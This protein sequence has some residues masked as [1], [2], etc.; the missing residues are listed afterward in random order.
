MRFMQRRARSSVRELAGV[1]VTLAVGIVLVLGSPMAG[2][3]QTFEVLH[4]FQGGT[5]DGAVPL[6]R[7][8][9][10]QGNDGYFYGTTG[11]GG[12]RGTVFQ[13]DTSGT[14]TIL[15]AFTGSPD[16]A[17]PAS[18]LIQAM[19]GALYGT[20]TRGG[21]GPCGAVGCGTVYKITTTGQYTQLWAFNGMNGESP[22]GALIQG[23]DGYF[24]GTT[25]RGGTLDYGVVFKMDAAGM[26]TTVHE[27]SLSEGAFPNASL[28]Q[29]RDGLLY[30]TTVGGGPSGRGTIFSMDPSGASFSVVHA[31]GPTEG[32]SPLSALLEASDG[33]LYGTTSQGGGPGCG[34]DGCGT[35]FR[36][37][38]GGANFLQ[39]HAFNEPFD[40]SFPRAPLIQARDGLFYGTTPLGASVVGCER[41]GC[42]T[43]F[44]MN[45]AGAITILHAFSGADGHA[46][47]GIIQ[48]VDDA[49]YGTTMGGGSADQG[50]VYRLTIP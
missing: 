20:T 7:G 35:T 37:D 18:G 9:L 16:G 29:A 34:G 25:W 43:I 1:S 3:A 17:F 46:A 39:L 33:H 21:G 15:H 11:G 14:I 44:S 13:M 40:G 6:E 19:D 22:N 30:G 10:L 32:L 41:V 50:V 31:F 8:V 48:G 38:L 49:F 4:E 47:T 36:I 2:S 45:A 23:T 24:Y 42:G 12:N 5:E 26:A 28:I 27:F